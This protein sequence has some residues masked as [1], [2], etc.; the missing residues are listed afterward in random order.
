MDGN[1]GRLAVP[2]ER[3]AI[4][5]MED[6]ANEHEMVRHH[7]ALLDEYSKAKGILSISADLSRD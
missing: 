7:W 3:R 6:W 2:E 4:P 1:S 5:I